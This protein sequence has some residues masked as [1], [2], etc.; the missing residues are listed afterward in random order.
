MAVPCVS[1]ER[2]MRAVLL[3]RLYL[4]SPHEPELEDVHMA[5]TLQGL[6]PRVVGQ[7]VV[8]VLLEQVAGVHLVAVLHQALGNR[9]AEE[10]S[11]AVPC[12]AFIYH[13]NRLTVDGQ[14][15]FSRMCC[16]LPPTMT[17]RNDL[18]H[19]IPL[20]YSTGQTFGHTSFW[21]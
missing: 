1:E 7:V 8:L 5:S 15:Q 6:V 12:N 13:G 20:Q 19:K 17:P 11:T 16:S 10:R 2:G 18:P 4:G 3:L 21:Y 14:L 9:T